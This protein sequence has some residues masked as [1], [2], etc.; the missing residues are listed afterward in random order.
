M[1]G[2]TPVFMRVGEQKDLREGLDPMGEKQN[3]PFALSSTPLG[4]AGSN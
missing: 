2:P 3:Q 4:A 1:I